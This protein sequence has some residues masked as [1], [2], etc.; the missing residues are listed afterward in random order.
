MN[1]SFRFIQQVPKCWEMTP[2]SDSL[3]RE[4]PNNHWYVRT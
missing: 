2:C 3:M 4:T 1:T